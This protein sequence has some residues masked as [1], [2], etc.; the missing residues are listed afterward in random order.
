MLE[1]YILREKNEGCGLPMMVLRS[2][3]RKSRSLS[4]GTL[5]N[6]ISRRGRRCGDAKIYTNPTYVTEE[7]AVT[8]RAVKEKDFTADTATLVATVHEQS[9]IEMIQ[10]GERGSSNTRLS[11]PSHPLGH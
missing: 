6:S 2:N 9:K 1:G 10:R 7:E 4:L 3:T 8:L 11:H 5:I